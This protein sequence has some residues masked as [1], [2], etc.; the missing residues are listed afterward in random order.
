MKNAFLTKIGT[1]VK[2]AYS[3]FD[4]VVIRGYI[5]SFFFEG[6]IVNFLRH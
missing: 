3:C 5:R 2:F 1:N 4:R 6:A